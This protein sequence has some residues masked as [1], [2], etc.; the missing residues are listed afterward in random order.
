MARIIENLLIEG[1]RG[2][3]GKQIVYR[4]HGNKTTIG[5]MPRFDPNQ[6]ATDSQQNVREQFGS[7]SAYATGAMG[8]EE[9]KKAYQRKAKPGVTAY[10]MAMRDFLKAPVVKAIETATYNGTPGS[11]LTITAKDDFR[12]TSV[13]VSIYSANGV[14]IEEGDAVLDAINRLKW[15]YGASQANAA[16]PGSVIRAVATDLP[17]N[18]GIL[19]VTV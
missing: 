17:G 11:F 16:P 14:L 19:E 4:K 1:A 7:A 2:N 3:V 10:N 13:K 12:V 18:T 15:R 8:N 9:L 5:K 6:P